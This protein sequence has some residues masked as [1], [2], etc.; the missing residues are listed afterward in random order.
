MLS[1]MATGAT[2]AA[3]AAAACAGTARSL[4]LLLPPPL[5]DIEP[6]RGASLVADRQTW[7]QVEMGSCHACMPEATHWL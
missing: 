2:R 1:E 4:A 6:A 5:N 3:S 7:R